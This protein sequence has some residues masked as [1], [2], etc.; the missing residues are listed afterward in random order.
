MKLHNL[1]KVNSKC[2]FATLS[3]EGADFKSRGQDLFTAAVITLRI[4]LVLVVFFRS[5]GSLPSFFLCC[6]SS[7]EAA[8]E[9]SSPPGPT[10]QAAQQP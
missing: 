9:N 8:A 2:V 4:I 10:A 1:T 7:D 6:R 3:H 5:V